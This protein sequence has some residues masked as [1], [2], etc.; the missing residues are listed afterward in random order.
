VRKSKVRRTWRQY[1][2]IHVVNAV[3]TICY[4]WRIRSIKDCTLMEQS[5][6]HGGS[7]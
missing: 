4:L 2:F 5:D 3:A 6:S 7:S 1:L